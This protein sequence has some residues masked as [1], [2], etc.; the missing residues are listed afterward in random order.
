LLVKPQFEVGKE[1]LPADGV[2][3]DPALHARALNGVSRFVNEETPWRVVA[4]MVSPIEGEKGNI[5]FF[6]H[7][8]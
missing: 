6:I 1:A 2:V 7:A 4:D 5:E 3:R 8:R